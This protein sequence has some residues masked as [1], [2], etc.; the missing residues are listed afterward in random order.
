MI[1]RWFFTHKQEGTNDA[2]NINTHPQ[3]RGAGA[4]S[5]GHG[6]DGRKE[7]RPKPAP[8][9][10]DPLQGGRVPR[11]LPEEVRRGKPPRAGQ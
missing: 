1:R 7:T 11:L 3:T 8:H 2:E 4:G 6:H 9:H 10:G 5:D